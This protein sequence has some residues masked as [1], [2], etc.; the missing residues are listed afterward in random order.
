VDQWDA[1]ETRAVPILALHGEVGGAR[2][3]QDLEISVGN[4]VPRD[5]VEPPTRGFSGRS[6][7]FIQLLNRKGKR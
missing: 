3:S 7:P 2:G 4:V 6:S 1:I 5:G